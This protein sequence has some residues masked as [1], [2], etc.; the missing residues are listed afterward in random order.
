[1]Q[2]WFLLIKVDIT[3]PLNKS[4]IKEGG[5]F[6]YIKR[7]QNA[8]ALSIFVG[9]SYSKDQLMHTFLYNFEEGGKY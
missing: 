7:F 2:T 8:H 4:H 5:V 1:M 9:N 3:G 6:I